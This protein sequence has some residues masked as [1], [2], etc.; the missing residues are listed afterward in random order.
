MKKPYGYIGPK[1]NVSAYKRV[2]DSSDDHDD[3]LLPLNRQVSAASSVLSPGGLKYFDTYL[4]NTEPSELLSAALAVINSVAT[5]IFCPTIRDGPIYR[6]TQH[7]LVTS[8]HLKGTL[9]L[10][11]I[12]NGTDIAKPRSVVM[13][14]VL[15]KATNGTQC[16]ASDVLLDMSAGVSPIN[17]LNLLRNPLHG[18]RF[19]VLRSA[20]FDLSPHSVS[21]YDP[22]IPDACVNSGRIVPFEFFLPLN[23]LVTFNAH[24]AALSSVVDNSFHIICIQAPAFPVTIVDKYPRVSCTYQ[25]RVRFSSPG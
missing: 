17:V 1:R 12:S 5:P 8:W 9:Y 24:A 11:A 14:L 7:A 3:V 15:D 13:F 2:R 10:D 25:S 18:S 22:A 23:V 16:L 20:T 6:N 21:V 19:E 4:L